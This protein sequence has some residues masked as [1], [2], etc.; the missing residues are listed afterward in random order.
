MDIIVSYLR[1]V[2]KRHMNFFSFRELIE[3][4]EENRLDEIIKLILDYDVKSEYN[5]N[6]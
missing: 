5:G 1:N 3:K 6:S 4:L 2:N